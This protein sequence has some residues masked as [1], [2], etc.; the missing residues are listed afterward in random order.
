MEGRLKAT[1]A[2]LGLRDPETRDQTGAD[3]RLADSRRVRG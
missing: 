1:A 2:L 3:N